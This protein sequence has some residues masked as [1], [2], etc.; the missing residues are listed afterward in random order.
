MSSLILRRCLFY[1]LRLFILIF[2]CLWFVIILFDRLLLGSDTPVPSAFPLFTP[3]ALI[4]DTNRCYPNSSAHH[5]TEF[6]PFVEL[7]PYHLNSIQLGLFWTPYFSADALTKKS[8]SF[9]HVIFGADDDQSVFYRPKQCFTKY[10][11]CLFSTNRAHY[12]I[13]KS[14]IFHW[15]DL[16]AKDL[17]PGDRS[18][19]QLWTLYNLEAPPHT[20]RLPEDNDLLSFNLTAN[21]RSDSHINI[22]YGRIVP[23]RRR[24]TAEVSSVDVANKSKQIAWFVSNCHTTSHREDYVKQLA[25]Y[26]QVDVYGKCGHLNCLPP[27]S[28]ECYR[29]IARE[30][31]FY[32]SFENSICRDY[33]TEKLFNI[34]DYNL[35]PI[36]FGGANY[37]DFMPPHSYIDATEMKPVD[38]AALLQKLSNDPAEYL[39]YFEWKAN[40]G[41]DKQSTHY[42]EVLFCKLCEEMEKQQLKS[43]QSSASSLTAKAINNWYFENA[44]N[45]RKL[46][47]F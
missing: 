17:P 34:L 33:V 19:S 3:C 23:K 15:R 27:N 42:N 41:T 7:R 45:V 35:I 37:S 24:K 12:P 16:N 44:C 32:L 25:R 46:Q 13:A 20:Q 28:Y 21:Y 36:V 6:S 18:P 4:N 8:N 2:L 11:R 9:F 43:V 5:T 26:I 38:L 22:P 14:V 1:Y 10:P 29:K 40:F 30:Y 39:K 47:F 31:R